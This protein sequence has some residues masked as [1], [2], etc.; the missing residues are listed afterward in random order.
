MMAKVDVR[1]QIKQSRICVEIISENVYPDQYSCDCCVFL[2]SHSHLDILSNLWV[3][4]R[5]GFYI[6]GN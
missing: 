2:V 5:N 4:Y 6:S 1:V 3:I